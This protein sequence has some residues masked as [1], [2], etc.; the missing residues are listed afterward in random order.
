MRARWQGYRHSLS[1][2]R[3]KSQFEYGMKLERCLCGELDTSTIG[4]HFSPE[5]IRALRFVNNY[6][7]NIDSPSRFLAFYAN[8]H[9]KFLC[10]RD[11]ANVTP[12]PSQIE[13]LKGLE[14]RDLPISLQSNLNWRQINKYPAQTLLPSF[15]PPYQNY[16]SLRVRYFP[17][18]DTL[19]RTLNMADRSVSQPQHSFLMLSLSSIRRGPC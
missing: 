7:H 8:Y 1:R 17:Y 14:P 19:A 18:S 13:Y 12:L 3:A 9:A 5:R 4:W 2:N 10:I 11:M 16:I 6:R 15:F